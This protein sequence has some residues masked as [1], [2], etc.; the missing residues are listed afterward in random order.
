MK[1][2]R[3]IHG[4]ASNIDLNDLN[5]QSIIYT[6]VPDLFLDFDFDFDFDFDSLKQMRG[7]L[8]HHT[9]SEGL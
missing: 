1:C 8:I 3:G 6:E 9:G 7:N 2:I 4:Y 5:F